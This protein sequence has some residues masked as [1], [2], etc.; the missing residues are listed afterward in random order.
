MLDTQN[1]AAYD[2]D[3]G[4]YVAYLRGHV[5]RRRCVRRTGGKDFGNWHEPRMVM[6]LDPQD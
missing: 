1:I 6:M 4:E 2:E 5:G 3:A